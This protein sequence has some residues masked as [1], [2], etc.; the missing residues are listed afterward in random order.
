MSAE[1]DNVKVGV[2]D[3]IRHLIEKQIDRLDARDRRMLE[4]ASVAGAEFSARRCRRTGRGRWQ[5]SRPAA[6]N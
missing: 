6:R 3:S 2:P 4:A 5:T 1:I